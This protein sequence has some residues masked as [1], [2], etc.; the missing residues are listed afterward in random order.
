MLNKK[1]YNLDVLKNEIIKDKE[2][3]R[4]KINILSQKI[5]DIY[6]Y[7]E[8]DIKQELKNIVEEKYKD[9]F[10]S[11]ISKIKKQ[12]NH[13]LEKKAKEILSTVIQRF[14]K[15]INK[16]LTTST[17][18]L[19]SDSEKGKII[20]KDGRNI[21]SFEQITGT[22]LIIDETPNIILIS[23]FDPLRREV[24]KQALQRLL[25]KEIIHP[26]KIEDEVKK[27]K[28]QIQ[29]IILQKGQEAS[30]ILGYYDFPE[31]LVRI[32]GSLHFR[33][34]FGQN[35]LEHSIEVAQLSEMLAFEL[36]ANPEIS[37]MAGLFHDIGKALDHTIQGSHVELGKQLLKQ[38]NI[39]DNVIRAMQSHHNE[40]KHETVESYIVDTA[41]SI[42]SSRPGA[43]NNTAE[44]YIQR[45]SQLENLIYDFNGVSDVYA[46][47]S[48]RE[49]RVFVEPEIISDIQ[50]IELSKKIAEKIEN[51]FQIPGEI[52]IALIREKRI[53]EYIR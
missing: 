9:D 24:A 26:A 38:Y 34:S 13:S 10:L 4:H 48:G 16:S 44:L 15:K 32:L 41:D 6:Q 2:I 31:E 21:K 42:S 40:Y 30:E 25:E 47:S 53:T 52:K 51:E 3:L 7:N 29:E 8:D 12:Y 5:S 18:K 50:A 28:K 37:K 36:G 11:Y 23:S 33:T 45:M 1:E 22:Q 20:G 46:V 43:R 39:D 19:S 14:S 17:V 27:S 35:V 49:I